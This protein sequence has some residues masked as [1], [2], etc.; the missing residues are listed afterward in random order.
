MARRFYSLIV[1]RATAFWYCKVL[2]VLC[3]YDMGRITRRETVS[4]IGRI[5]SIEK[6][7]MGVDNL[8]RGLRSWAN[9]DFLRE[10]VDVAYSRRG[11]LVQQK[12]SCKTA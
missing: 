12:K 10:K 6:K 1:A 8:R 5:M 9:W 7:G 2:S 11:L 4:R 3:L